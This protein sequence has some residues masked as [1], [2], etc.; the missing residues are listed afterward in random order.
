MAAP[1][2]L[3]E[4][5]TAIAA[6][7]FVSRGGF[8]PAPSD[9]VPAL[10]GQPAASVVLVGNVGPTM[11]RAFD[12]SGPHGGGHPLNTWSK[13]AIS[14]AAAELGAAALFP[15]KG[16]PFLP[17]QRWAQKAE[18]VHSSPLGIL[19]HPDYGLWHAYRG[20][21]AFTEGIDFGQG[22]A[23]PSPCGSC[24]E[25]PCLDACPV[26]AFDGRAYDVPVCVGHL[27]GESAGECM[28]GGCLAR[29]ACPVGSDY[30]YEPAQ[31]RFHMTAFVEANR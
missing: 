11:W 9:G 19:I 24:V 12:S 21:L 10:D 8:V 5:E 23:R 17:F 18:A 7:G 15:F 1:V 28:V 26:G 22:D 31:T 4:I 2:T 16:P 20:A 29:R 14:A 3:S 30:R 13:K 6:H 25:K 27:A